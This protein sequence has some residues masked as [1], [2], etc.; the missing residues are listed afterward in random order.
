MILVDD[1]CFE[2]GTAVKRYVDCIP[3]CVPCYN[4]WVLDMRDL[5]AWSKRVSAMGAHPDRRTKRA[6]RLRRVR[7]LGAVTAN[8]NGR[9]FALGAQRHTHGKR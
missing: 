7:E 3:M 1:H 4:A 5:R 8:D 6:E 9:A 2:C